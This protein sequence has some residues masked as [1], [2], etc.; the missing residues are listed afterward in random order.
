MSAIRRRGTKSKGWPI[1]SG[2]R[3]CR[4]TRQGKGKKKARIG[5]VKREKK[6]RKTGPRAASPH[7][8]A[9]CPSC[10]ADEMGKNLGEKKRTK[11][12]G[13]SLRRISG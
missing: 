12:Q 1:A 9:P 11:L 7:F 2:A 6:L 8:P 5:P 4:I 3:L 13:R 10:T